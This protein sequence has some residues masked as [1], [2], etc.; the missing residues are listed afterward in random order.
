MA[1]AWP[2]I[3]FIF[4]IAAIALWIFVDLNL[5]SIA[6]AEGVSFA[7]ATTE[8]KAKFSKEWVEWVFANA[9]KCDPTVSEARFRPHLR[10][11]N[12]LF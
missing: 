7:N 2:I 10:L 3:P 9:I 5:R 6:L 4:I 1:L 12:F 11:L 8:P